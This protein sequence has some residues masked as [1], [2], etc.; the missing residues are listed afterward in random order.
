[1]TEQQKINFLSLA[2][3]SWQRGILHDLLTYKTISNPTGQVLRGKA[4]NYSIRYQESL[5]NLFQRVHN[6][7]YAI[8]YIPGIR[9]GAYSARYRLVI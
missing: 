4:R 1:M 9:G 6:A 7:G 2:K 5:S 3:G 8:E